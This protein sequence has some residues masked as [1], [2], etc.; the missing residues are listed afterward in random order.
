[1]GLFD[2]EGNVVVHTVFLGMHSLSETGRTIELPPQQNV[3]RARELS[4]KLQCAVSIL[5]LLRHLHLLA[6]IS[7]VLN[8]LRHE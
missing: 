6:K 5:E 3:I 1:M 7:N 4:R 2:G 8:N